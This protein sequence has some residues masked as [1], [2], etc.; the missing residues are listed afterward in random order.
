MLSTRAFSL[1]EILV[2]LAVIGILIA[3]VVPGFSTWRTR[4]AVGT[5]VRDVESVLKLARSKSLASEDGALYG[6]FFTAADN[7]YSFCK[8][9]SDAGGGTYICGT[10]INDHFLPASLVFCPTP[11]DIIFSKLTGNTQAN[12][13]VYFYNK[14]TASALCSDAPALT[15]CITDKTCGGVEVLQSGV[16]YE[17]K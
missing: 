6:V 16:V 1:I 3:V 9:P 15:L 7:K 14:N 12:A 4:N 11:S 13:T 10:L 2:V 17:K 5:G 8:N